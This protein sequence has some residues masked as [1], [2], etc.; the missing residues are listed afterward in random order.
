MKKRLVPSRVLR[1]KQKSRR[2]FGT[3]S[4][5]V[6][7]FPRFFYSAA[8]GTAFGR[9]WDSLAWNWSVSVEPAI[10]VVEALPAEIA[11]ATASK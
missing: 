1:R 10:A 9:P 3:G 5:P 7:A 6:A 2:L 4:S 11:T 8:F